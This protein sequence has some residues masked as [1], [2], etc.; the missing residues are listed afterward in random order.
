M[1]VPNQQRKVQAIVAMACKDESSRFNAA[2]YSPDVFD[3]CVCA[4]VMLKDIMICMAGYNQIPP[5]NFV[6]IDRQPMIAGISGKAGNASCSK[7]F[8]HLSS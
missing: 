5:E 6:V 1:S 4:L 3:K 2:M 7:C 8:K